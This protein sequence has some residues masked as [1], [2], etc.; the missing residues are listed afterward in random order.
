MSEK[1]AILLFTHTPK[2][3]V[4][5]KTFQPTIG[6]HGN[7]QVAAKLIKQS[8]IISRQTNI[9]VFTCYT[10]D[11]IGKTFGE[12]FA[13]AIESVYQ[14]GYENVITIGNDCATLTTEVLL[15]AKAKLNNQQL[16][17]G[18]NTNGGVYLI[19]M[20]K[21]VYNRDSFITL[22]WEKP[23]LQQDLKAYAQ[24]IEIS[25]NWF[26]SRADINTAA[27]FNKALKEL[28]E[29]T[30]KRYFIAII[31]A[32]TFKYIHKKQAI[33]YITLAKSIPSRAPPVL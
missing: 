30:L 27:D 26:A 4:R 12:R 28:E 11:Q 14:K 29:S 24:K 7:E 22:S 6:K 9:P 31:I 25:I 33:Q 23:S 1:T 15:E 3:E 5:Y 13:N 17:I 10:P 32:Y 19:G 18:P 2:A 16:V 8:L 21:S 20:H